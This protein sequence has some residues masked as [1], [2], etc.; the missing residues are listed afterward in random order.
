MRYEKEQRIFEDYITD[1]NLKQSRRRKEILNIF[2]KNERHLT[3][4]ELYIMVKEKCPSVG[5]T[6]IYRTLKLLC[7]CGISRGLK[8]EDGTTRYEHLYRH[9]HHDHLICIKCGKFTEVISPEIEKLQ[10]AMAKKKGFTLKRHRLQ[11]YGICKRCNG[12]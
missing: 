1:K 2:L 6:T 5:H 7:D 8:L 9:E 12:K 11:I 10:E 4:E 3:A